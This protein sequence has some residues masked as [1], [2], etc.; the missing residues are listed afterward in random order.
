MNLCACCRVF[1]IPNVL[2]CYESLAQGKMDA[3]KNLDEFIHIP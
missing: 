1:F 2:T 3:I